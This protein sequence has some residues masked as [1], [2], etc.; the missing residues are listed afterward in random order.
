MDPKPVSRSMEIFGAPNNRRAVGQA[1]LCDAQIWVPD[2]GFVI[3]QF[4]VVYFHVN[5]TSFIRKV[6]SKC[7]AVCYQGQ[8][9]FWKRKDSPILWVLFEVRLT[10]FYLQHLLAV[11]FIYNCWYGW[12]KHGAMQHVGLQCRSGSSAMLKKSN[13]TKC[14]HSQARP[15]LIMAHVYLSPNQA[16]QYSIKDWFR[17]KNWKLKHGRRGTTVI[18]YLFHLVNECKKVATDQART[19]FVINL[20]RILV[21]AVWS[22]N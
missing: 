13:E 8:K 7:S 4:Q 20:N 5:G 6:S 14:L 10:C 2:K 22:S 9:L 19:I 17:D 1:F 18:T 21:S 11:F 15:G 3:M 16:L 12:R